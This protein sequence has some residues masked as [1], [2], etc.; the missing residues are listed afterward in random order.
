M[1]IDD[2]ADHGSGAPSTRSGD[3]DWAS[4]AHAWRDSS[5]RPD[6]VP[7][8]EARL[9]RLAATASGAE[10][11][12]VL[13]GEVLRYDSDAGVARSVA[14][15]S[16][17]LESGQLDVRV[18]WRDQVAL[19]LGAGVAPLMPGV[20]AW[21][22]RR[23]ATRQLGH[24]LVVDDALERELTALDEVGGIRP[25]VAPVLTR[26]IGNRHADLQLA[27][28]ERA[29]SES[30]V[31]A[32]AFSVAAVTRLGAG[33]L[34][35]ADRE[36]LIN[37]AALRL[38]SL[39]R[40]ARA[41][42]T[43]LVFEVDQLRDLTLTAAVM[44]R[45]VDDHEHPENRQLK[46]TLTLPVDYP[47][48]FSLL[49]GLADWAEDHRARGG[50]PITIRFAYAADVREEWAA[51]ANNRWPTP[52]YT[53][54]AA[55]FGQLQRMLDWALHPERLEGFRVLVASEHAHDHA[56][57]WRLARQR[58]VLRKVDHE[59]R[60]SVASALT[61]VMK[62]VV[63]GVRMRIPVVSGEGESRA[64]DYLMRRIEQ[65]AAGV[66]A[67]TDAAPIPDLSVPPMGSRRVTIADPASLEGREWFD[68]VVDR[69]RAGAEPTA[70]AEESTDAAVVGRAAAA[71]GLWSQRRG[72]T[73]AT[74]L[75]AVAES[76]ANART[77]LVVSAML[78]SG[79]TAAEAD[80]EVTAAIDVTLAAASAAE[81]LRLVPNAEFEPV[82]VTLALASRTS[83]IAQPAGQLAG[84]LAAGSGVLLKPAPETRRSAAA[85]VST[86]RD[87]GIP[88]ELVVVLDPAENGIVQHVLG[89]PRVGRVVH[90]GS[91]HIAKALRHNF[92][93]AA[94]LSTTGGRNSII[95][96][97]SA[98]VDRAVSDVLT[99]AFWSAGQAA[100]TVGTVIL[101][102]EHERFVSLLTDAVASLTTGNPLHLSTEVATLV[103]PASG[104]MLDC[105]TTLV[106]EERWL[107]APRQLDDSGRRW[108]PG[109]VDH[110][111]PGSVRHVAERRAPVLSI[112][113]VD[114]F[115]DA[116]DI[117]TG[118]GFGLFAGL[119]SGDPDELTVWLDSANA[120][121][122]AANTP[123]VGAGWSRHPVAGWARSNVGVS[124]APGGYLF[125]DQFGQWVPENPAADES[126]TLEGMSEG[127]A[128]LITA[129][130]PAL[131]FEEFDWVR[132]AARDDESVWRAEFSLER[133]ISGT[134]DGLAVSRYS[135]VP[136]TIRLT[137]SGSFA[138]LVRVL[139]AATRVHAPVAVSSA[140]PLPDP[141][142][143]FFRSAESPVAEVVV[144]A[145]SR[146]L[147]R[148]HAGDIVTQRAR[149]VGGDD[150]ALRRVLARHAGVAAITG[151]V[152][153]SGRAELANFV[154]EQAVQVG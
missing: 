134:S 124:R 102:G 2:R 132:S 106:D 95:V 86:L 31:G 36:R 57:A 15:L 98:N 144:E 99:S 76:L 1:T 80:L 151:D 51:A 153:A 68:E 147:A 146:W 38:A 22:G 91:R 92:P 50:A 107:V 125:V 28:V 111:A 136:T 78:E 90:S 49:E 10:F 56:F 118:P 81:S 119:Q 88:E 40:L 52:A 3:L 142:I 71:A 148:A 41:T 61:D 64:A 138:E 58:G 150:G 141:L 104:A 96:S 133:D 6:T 121:G 145:Q 85:L 154:A 54:P 70:V 17:S 137:E 143:R 69:V 13:A 5:S 135:P 140:K 113:R 25:V 18:P 27:A 39:A 87:G 139:A 149:L 63:G 45:L 108:S 55:T 83:P 53:D 43:E 126:V 29:V 82:R 131:S 12:S 74:V 37:D 7:A 35:S 77:E 19:A 115:E 47:Q 79:L 105:L 120:G 11:L 114:T 123:N 60:W 48:S 110:V 72:T 100:H 46:A 73:R 122:L 67:V 152:T 127:V 26:A 128:A 94:L 20:A 97:D 84:A 116:L 34:G 66:G 32:V 23:V 24:L 89:D 130:Q 112:V 33:G 129:T 117:Q 30:G 44:L 4:V 9:A 16:A 93:D 103:R 59:V 101:V 21:F 42:D 75:R 8:I 14:R 62:R 65:A 109:L